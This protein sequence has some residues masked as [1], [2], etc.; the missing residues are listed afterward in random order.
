MKGCKDLNK[1]AAIALELSQSSIHCVEDLWSA[2]KITFM[3]SPEPQKMDPHFLEE[4]VL[5]SF[6]LYLE[7]PGHVQLPGGMIPQAEFEREH[8]NTLLRVHKFW[9]YWHS[10]MTLDYRKS[11]QVL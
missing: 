11:R 3:Y 6:A 1:T 2:E 8:K 7:H 9:E 10:S 5:R 4:I